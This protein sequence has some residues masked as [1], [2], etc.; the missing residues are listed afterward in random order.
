[1]TGFKPDIKLSSYQE[2]IIE[3]VLTAIKDNQPVK[4]AVNAVAGSGKCLGKDTPVLMYDGTIKPAQDIK[5]GDYLMGD[6]SQP[7]LV[8]STT[9]G[10]D[11]LFRIVPTKGDSWVCNSKHI[12]TLI[13]SVTGEVFDIGID[14]YLANKGTR[15]NSD[16]KLF[17]VPVNFEEQQSLPLDPY[18][19]GLWLGDGTFDSPS[20]TNASDFIRDYCQAIVPR[21]DCELAVRE[22]PHK[23]S[24]NLRFRVGTRGE[25]HPGTP[26]TIWRIL[27]SEFRINGEKRIPHAY[28]ISQRDARLQLLA[29]LID[30]DG[31]YHCGYFEITTKYSGL[32]DDIL[33]LTRSLG[34]AA[35]ASEKIASVKS[36]GFVGKYWRITI[37][38]HVNLIPCQLHEVQERKQKKDVLRTGFKIEPIGKGEYFGFEVDGNGRFLLGDFTV[39]HNSTTIKYIALFAENAGLSPEDIRITVFG[40]K[41]AKD[42]KEKLGKQWE[43]SIGTLHS[44]G[45]SLLQKELGGWSRANKIDE[46]KYEK[47]ARELKYLSGRGKDKSIGSLIE[48]GAIASNGEPSFIKII[49][50]LRL[51][52]KKPTTENI[53]EI[54]DHFQIENIVDS[55]A[56]AI[57]AA[58]VLEQG[59]VLGRQKNID[60]T[61][62]I[63][64]PVVWEVHKKPWFMPY[65]LL[66]VDESQ[67][68]NAAQ[69]QLSINLCNPKNGIAI[70]VGDPFQS[71]FGFSGADCDSWGK[72]VKANN[73]IEMPLSVCYR[74]GTEHIKLVNKLFPDIAIKAYED[75]HPGEI[76]QIKE[77]DLDKYLYK[78][79]RNIMVIGRKTAPLVSQCIKL[80]SR[81]IPAQV[82]GR[83][84]GQTLVREVEAIAKTQGFRWEHFSHWVEQYKAAKLNQYQGKE[85][86]EQLAEALTDR[87]EAILAIYEAI[88]PKTLQAFKTYA[89]DLFS[90]TDEQ[91]VIYLS[92]VHSAKGLERNDIVIIKP[93]D[94]PMT[95]RKIKEW[96]L[97]QEDNLHYVALTRAKNRLIIAG[98]CSWYKADN[99]QSASVPV[100]QPTDVSQSETNKT[101]FEQLDT[102][103]KKLGAKAVIMQAI[104]QANLSEIEEVLAILDDW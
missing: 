31:Y 45:F 59:K 40:K 29:G 68:L 81:G 66:A 67:D 49:D 8:L 34:F 84:I 43:Q 51:T 87:I 41:N 16:A 20:L 9:S 26:H 7:K 56:C 101:D 4:I 79:A 86:F 97:Q 88:E 94:L 90:D 33:F 38:G 10:I 72:I 85:N 73:A 93:N 39:T 46:Y 80:I 104:Q 11:E 19:A 75:N 63:W 95:W 50:L 98:D 5:V 54:V 70:Y 25:G 65:R 37:T 91:A 28:L 47:I 22:E 52:L 69:L 74:C 27:K 83:D 15:R 89:E 78:G 3:K 14:E 53:N 92:T 21:Y 99:S 44:T 12:L 6:D 2:A 42:L 77:N 24:R 32:K 76:I 35:Y 48:S 102:I 60:F 13:N 55:R 18:L 61:D 62:Q 71:V 96:Q 30:T 58:K 36:L 1:M 64:L 100:T 103:I 23:N 82:K 17:K 57:A